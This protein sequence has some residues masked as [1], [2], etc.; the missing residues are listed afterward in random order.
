MINIFKYYFSSTKDIKPLIV[1]YC[2]IS[3]IVSIISALF[4]LFE[5]YLIDSITQKS[6]RVFIVVICIYGGL[7]LLSLLLNLFLNKYAI[8]I[9]NNSLNQMLM[10]NIDGS[11][12]L[13]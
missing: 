7:S 13:I 12:I 6:I 2:G 10:N 5:G 11:T 1:F 3:V 4:P 8:K 9:S